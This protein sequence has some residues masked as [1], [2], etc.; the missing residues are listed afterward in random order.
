[1]TNILINGGKKQSRIESSAKRKE[2]GSKK[3]AKCNYDNSV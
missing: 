2:R 1:M 3:I